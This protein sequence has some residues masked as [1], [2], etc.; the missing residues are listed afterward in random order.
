MNDCAK[1]LCKKL[2]IKKMLVDKHWNKKYAIIC[3][4]LKPLKI[5]LLPPDTTNCIELLDTSVIN[6]LNAHK[7]RMFIE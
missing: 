4:W 1:K 5:K 3:Y 6:F 2:Q 7:H